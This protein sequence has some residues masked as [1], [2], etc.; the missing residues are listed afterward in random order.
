[1]K[2]AV[3][4]KETQRALAIAA[5]TDAVEK[6]EKNGVSIEIAAQTLLSV[7]STLLLSICEADDAAEILESMAAV[8][9]S[10]RITEDDDA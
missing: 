9:R 7:A 4:N 2:S 8:I 6:C 10:G 5:F 1:M 3:K